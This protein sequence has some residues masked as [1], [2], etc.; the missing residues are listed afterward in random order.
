RRILNAAVN[1]AFGGE[2]N[3][4]IAFPERFED[5]AVADVQLYKL[6]AALLKSRFKVLKVAGVGK[7]VKDREVPLRM[8]GQG[9]MNKVRADESRAA[10]DQQ[11]HTP[12]TMAGSC[13]LRSTF[14]R[15]M[16]LACQSDSKVPASVHHPSS[17]VWRSVPSAM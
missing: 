11:L 9:V 10:R 4:G 2:V 1:V 5:R 8:L 17:S 3:D 13:A 6:T 16:L 7:L 14:S 12:R 15:T